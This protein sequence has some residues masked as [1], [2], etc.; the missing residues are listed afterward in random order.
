MS[1]KIMFIFAGLPH[2]YNPI[3]DK[4]NQYEDSEVV[5]VIPSSRSSNLGQGVYET[6]HEA[7]FK[8][9]KLEEYKAWYGKPFMRNLATLLEKEQPKI[10]VLIWPYFLGFMWSRKLKRILKKY[11][12]KLV[13]KD[14]PFQIPK[15]KDSLRYYAQEVFDENLEPI[16]SKGLTFYLKY[17]LL[18]KIRK[19]YFNWVDAHVDYTEDAYEVFESYGVTKEK[20]FIIYNSPDTEQI[21]KIKAQI[22]QE[23]PILPFNPY[24]LI[25][26]GRLVKWKKVNQLIE[27]FSRLKSKYA[28]AELLIVGKGPEKENLEK[29]AEATGYQSDI[30]FIGAIYDTATLGKYLQSSGIYVLAGMGGLS[31][32][33]AMC[34][35]KPVVC[36]VCDGTEKKL[37]RENFNGRFFRSDD[38]EHFYQVLDELLQQPEH[39]TDMG[40]NSLKIIEEEVNV[41]A[42]VQ[43]YRQ[44]FT[45]LMEK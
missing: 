17:K 38:M 31:I 28:E 15:Y 23:S 6:A 35:A 27:V 44:A 1:H 19:K 12:I 32:N 42:V 40:K 20:I 3:L 7:N 25:H 39:L 26:V 45:Y 5:V 33:D 2:Y 9:Y 29:Q 30:H 11:N 13:H 14:I 8:L 18:T 21:F 10:L 37:V 41:D 36:S 24:R 34:F 16:K 4:L 43:G 22:E